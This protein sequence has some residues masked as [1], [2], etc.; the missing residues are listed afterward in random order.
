[1][2]ERQD[3]HDV[4]KFKM[5]RRIPGTITYHTSCYWVDGLLVDTGCAHCAQEFSR[6]T[7]PLPVTAVVNTHS[8]EDHIGN[9]AV[10]QRRGASIAAHPL[11]LPFLADPKSLRLQPYRHIFW[12]TPRPST[13]AAIGSIVETEHHVFEVVP[14]PGH[15]DDH[16]CLY[17]RREGW[18]FTGDA[19]VGGK[20]RALRH[21]FDIHGII[22]SL[23]LLARLPA[24]R[25]F[26]ASGSVVD[27]PAAA[28]AR[29]IAYLE[30]T[31]QRVMALRD[32]GKSAAQ[33]RQ[34]L[35]GS[36]MLIN[37]VTL[38]NFSGL[39]LV[40]SYLRPRSET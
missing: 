38:G 11:A 31:G 39:N 37:Y 6:A 27:D 3:L 17:E 23:K 2:I 24:S 20:D 21:E 8:H 25:L 40:R 32:Q 26:P 28:L 35:F 16:I 33:I 9:N 12:G 29:K 14:T 4:V 5:A 22:A 1:M 7:L 15:S 18:L 36:E 13:A 34:D 19:Y 30:E 10:C